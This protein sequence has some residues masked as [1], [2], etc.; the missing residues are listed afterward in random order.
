MEIQDLYDINRIKTGETTI[1]GNKIK[2]GRYRLTILICIFNS[3]NKMLIQHRQPFKNPWPN[4]WDVTVGGSSIAGET[5]QDA[6][7]R[8]LFEEIG[9]KLNFDNMRPA[10]TINFDGGFNDVY[11]INNDVNA[12]SLTLQQ[13]EVKEVK[14]ASMYEIIS[15]IDENIFIPYNKNYIELLFYLKDHTTTYL[16]K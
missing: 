3:E 4:L 10:L 6:A 9:L 12:N 8:E 15:M 13:E 2:K 5:S 1:R 14:W 16:K 7:E 11:L